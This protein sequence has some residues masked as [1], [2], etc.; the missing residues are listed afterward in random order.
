M[1]NW[2]LP[3]VAC[4]VLAAFGLAS[5]NL[6][7]KD[8]GTVIRNPTV[9]EMNQL[10]A[11]MGLPPKK[12]NTMQSPVPSPGIYIPDSAPAAP[13]IP[14]TPAAPPLEKIQPTTTVTPDLQ[15]KLGA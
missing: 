13:V 11:Q 3:L 6:T 7:P 14:I 4:G 8:S 9:D 2:N 5:C 15:K 1:M 10:D 12:S